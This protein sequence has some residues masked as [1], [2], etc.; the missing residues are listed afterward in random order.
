MIEYQWRVP[1][2]RCAG[3]GALIIRLPPASGP[4]QRSA[5]MTFSSTVFLFLFFPAVLTGYFVLPQRCRRLRNL[6]L[7]VCSL[8]F[9]FYGEP[10]G[11]LIMLVSIAGNY[12][13]ALALERWSARRR[14]WLV[15]SLL[16]NL[17]LLCTFKYLG[18]FAQNL[19]QLGLSVSVPDIVMPIGISFFTFQGMSYVFDV[20]QGT[21]R[22]QRNPLLVAL[23]IS[24]FPQLVAGPIV[25]Y[26]TIELELTSR[27]ETLDDASN[28]MRRFIFGLG[29]KLLLAN[30]MGVIATEVFAMDAAVTP[31]PVLWVGAI[32]YTFQIYFDFS[33]YSDMAIGI[34]HIFG[35]HFL[36][37]FN[38]PYI[39][40][41]ITEFWR[42]WHISLSGWFRD[43]VYIPLGG[44]RRGRARQ[45][46][47]ILIVWAL[48]GLWHG[49]AWN[50]VLWGLYFA[51]ILIAEKLFLGKLLQRLWRPLR[52]VYSLLLIVVG[53]VLFNAGSL[54]QVVQYTSGMFTNWSFTAAEG[55]HALYLLLE[56]R[57]ELLACVLLSMPVVPWLARKLGDRPW[58]EPARMIPALGVFV[59]SLLALVST[60]FNPFIYFRF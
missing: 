38:Y 44:N 28:G 22:A 31:A 26:E 60:T 19:Q 8:G 56:Y 39:S 4:V 24:L 37:N 32:A 9:Y 29:K 41:S 46:L 23:Y 40:Q 14:L 54:T 16:L 59:L 12:L 42:R 45:L 57:F 43:Y 50:F 11:I 27:R 35:F 17:G 15:L 13:I 36:E 49:A 34:G 47:N 18:F 52:H 25:R 51:V 30:P 55:K 48:T 1:S 7:L 5:F 10:R 3:A 20:Y 58:L 6:F 33:G 53:W 21:V 2:A